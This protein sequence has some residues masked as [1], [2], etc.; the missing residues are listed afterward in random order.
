MKEVTRVHIAKTAYD[1]EVA[2]KKQLEKYMHS[3]ES[4]TQDTDV[5]ADVEIRMTEI[6]AERG[7]KAGGV[8]AVDDVKALREQLGEPYE[9]A[10]DSGDIA[11]GSNAAG[12]SGARAAR[13]WYRSTDDAVLGGVLS[14]IAVYCNVNPVWTRLV[15]VLLL[16]VSFGTATIAYVLLWI[17]LPPARTV[18]EKLQLAGQPVT[19]ESIRAL[20]AADEAASRGR[21][22]PVVQNILAYGFG[23]LVGLMAIGAFI[24]TVWILIAALTLNADVARWTNSFMGLGDDSVWLVWLLFWIVIAGMLL[25]TTLLGLATYALFVKKLTK[26]MVLSG[27]VIIVLGIASLATV[28]GV[29]STQSL[30]VANESRAMVRETTTTLPKE[31]AQVKSVSLER[32]AQT[33]SSRQEVFGFGYVTMRYVAGDGPVRYELSGLPTAKVS[34]QIKGEAATIL[35]DIPESFRNSFVQPTL[36]V[37]GPALTSVSA[38]NATDV[39]YESVSQESLLVSLAPH[40]TLALSGAYTTVQVKGSGTVDLGASIVQN[41]EVHAE[42]N[43]HVNAG[44]VRSLTVTQP[45]VCTSGADRTNTTVTVAGVASGELTYNGEKRPVETYKT[46]CASVIIEP[47]DGDD[48]YEYSD[49]Q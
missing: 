46:A 37:Y 14:G 9:F 21:V 17:F 20:S 16:L 10:D 42:Q 35:L 7:V 1:I 38:K 31:F 25:L 15:F 30:R 8:I 40:T 19:V 48:G 49:G 39:R 32:K 24:T 12:A 5:I 28:V 11:V 43:L 34:V 41:L 3:L 36:T 44:T 23:T 45:D 4:Y 26:K 2:A 6:L 13:R 18:T 22:A 29:G 33:T 47:A 27:V